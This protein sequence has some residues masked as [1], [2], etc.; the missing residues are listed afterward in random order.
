MRDD[1]LMALVDKAIEDP[2]FRAAAR[3]DPE[4][5]V[6]AAGF[7]LQDD[8]LE[9]V[10]EAQRQTAGMSDDELDQALVAGAR[11]GVASPGAS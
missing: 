5:A 7:E 4:G 8:E 1:V 3:Q 6:K 9:A 11:Q 2:E 10:K